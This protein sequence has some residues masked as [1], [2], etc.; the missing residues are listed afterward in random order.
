MNLV[1][2]AS[3]RLGSAIAERLL[4]NGMQVK[5]VSRQPGKLEAL[6]SMG[7]EVIRGD[8]RDP[9]WMDGAMQN[10]RYLFLTAHGLVPPSRS[11][12]IDRVDDAGHRSIIDAA[13]RSSVE[14]IF[15]ISA[16][17]ARP[18]SPIKFGRIK[19]KIEEYI[20]VSDL[21]YTIVRPGA[22]IETHVIFLMAEPLR[23]FGKV[24]IFGK[25]KTPVTWISVGDVADFLV[26]CIEDTG[27]R[28]TIKLIGG[29]DIRSRIQ[30]LEIIERLLGKKAKRSH[31]PTGILRVMK[32]LSK[33]LNPSL[34]YLLEATLAEEYPSRPED[35]K[36]GNLDW[37]APTSVEGVVK[38][39]I[40]KNRN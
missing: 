27:A 12:S 30:V 21:E 37:I 25:G 8:L 26:R 23:Q 35:W 29:P 32:V 11:N 24:K 7:A 40:E 20:K 28:N 22:F 14:R 38:R 17:I 16:Y 39:W 18:D 31:L 1:I 6:K 13:K 15:F 5:A 34:S 4:Q 2:G 10:V 33:P 9:S 19:H 36:P 3:G